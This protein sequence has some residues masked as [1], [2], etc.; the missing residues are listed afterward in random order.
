MTKP[1]R[2]IELP[3]KHVA[4]D[5]TKFRL[6]SNGPTGS[7]AFSL[8]TSSATLTHKQ[9]QD[10]S[11]T[12]DAQ[13][14]DTES[15]V[16]L[17]IEVTNLK[18]RSALELLQ[19]LSA[20]QVAC[21][22][23]KDML[24]IKLMLVDDDMLDD[25][26]RNNQSLKEWSEHC[27]G[28]ELNV[29]YAFHHGALVD[30]ANSSDNGCG[31]LVRISHEDG[32]DTLITEI[33]SWQTHRGNAGLVPSGYQLQTHRGNAGVVPPG[34]LFIVSIGDFAEGAIV[35]NNQNG[36]A[37]AHNSVRP[38]DRRRVRPARPSSSR[39]STMLVVGGVRRWRR[40]VRSS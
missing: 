4:K 21:L 17:E 23:A 10:C 35:V 28:A 2:L 22:K 20:A 1:S 27:K 13:I 38:K 25:N 5:E 31:H 8:A 24:R 37:V 34:H 3:P 18:F 6:M 14:F 29:L 30:V 39:P 11:D 33:L 15:D 26:I 40:P 12:F 7:A 19:R 36:P 16:K 32:T 9:I